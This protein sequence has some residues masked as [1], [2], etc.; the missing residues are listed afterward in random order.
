M[1]GCALTDLPDPAGAPAVQVLEQTALMAHISFES[2][3]ETREAWLGAGESG[4][5]LA[6]TTGAGVPI[7][8]TVSF[9]LRSGAAPLV[10]SSPAGSLARPPEQ[11]YSPTYYPAVSW[12][13]VGDCSSLCGKRPARA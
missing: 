2:P 9:A 1:S 4:L 3:T 12:V 8:R 13:S 11:V 5:G 10:T 7:T 6:I